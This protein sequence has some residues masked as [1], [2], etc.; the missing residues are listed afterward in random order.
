MAVFYVMMLGTLIKLS[1][2][3]NLT[4][5]MLMLSHFAQKGNKIFK[6]LLA[7]S[8]LISVYVQIVLRL[9]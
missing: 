2:N 7:N 6:Q 8:Y 4:A 9:R 5:E 3:V 1:S